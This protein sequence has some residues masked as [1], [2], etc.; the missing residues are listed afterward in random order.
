MNDDE[1]WMQL[2]LLQANRAEKANEVPIGAVIIINNK[3]IA[4]AHNQSIV[5]NDATAHAEIQ[6][7]RL[8]GKKISNYRLNNATL[9]VTLEPCA[10]CYSAIINARIKRVVYGAND[11][12]KRA[13]NLL[14]I[15]AVSKLQISGGILENQCS[16][17]LKE[18]F[19]FRR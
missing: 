3:L 4:E 14:N 12:K 5:K 19:K 13:E 7:I 1:K 6:A 10:M 16:N 15:D 11:Q 18:F 2:A 8:A 9:Y 17:M